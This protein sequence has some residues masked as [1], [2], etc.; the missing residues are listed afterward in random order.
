VR[1]D[2]LAEPAHHVVHQMPAGWDE[3]FPDGAERHWYFDAASSRLVLLESFAAG[4]RAEGR[5]GQ[6][7]L[8]EYYRFDRFMDNGLLTDADFTPETLWPRA[9]SGTSAARPPGTAAS[10]KVAQNPDRLSK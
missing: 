7:A 5:A 10:A 3:L 6:E 8:L 2:D 1:R 9:G 4:G